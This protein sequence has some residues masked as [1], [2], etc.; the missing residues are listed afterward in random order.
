MFFDISRGGTMN[1]N[2][3]I[4]TVIIVG[5]L[6]SLGCIDS[7]DNSKQ[8][9]Q[10]ETAKNDTEVVTTPPSTSNPKVSVYC[11]GGNYNFTN[12][13]DE[14]YPVIQLF[15]EKYVALSPYNKN[16]W[17]AR[18]NKLAKLVLDSDKKYV[19]A[20]GEKIDMGFGYS[21][22]VK[23]IDLDGMKVWLEF[24]KDGMYI[25]DQIVA[26]DS[27]NHTWTCKL[28]NIQGENNVAVFRVHINQVF[29]S[30]A[31]EKIAQID[32]LWLIDY[33]NATTLNVGNK[34]G[35]LK[36]VKINNGMDKSNLGSLVFEPDGSQT[37]IQTATS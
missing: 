24:T 37:N 22:L 34:I 13:S 27:G 33:S 6:I 3:V 4:A 17:N 8:T 12:W 23:E 16:I 25:G 36:L 18:V 20:P 31:K 2:I 14:Q 28:D 5:F 9:I 19:I 32:G 21:L 7:K 29:D 1:R 35:H 26:T 15:G 10:S 11:V 30:I